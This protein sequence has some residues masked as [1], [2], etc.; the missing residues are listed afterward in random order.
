MTSPRSPLVIIF[1]TPAMSAG[2]GGQNG[3]PQ[4]TDPRS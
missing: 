2:F 1:D 4:R 3:P